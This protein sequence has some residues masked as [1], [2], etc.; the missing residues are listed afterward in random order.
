[1]LHYEF[2]MGFMIGTIISFI[3]FSIICSY[4]FYNTNTN[5]NTNTN[6]L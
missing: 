6:D 2:I 4:Y 5:T 3:S 1:M